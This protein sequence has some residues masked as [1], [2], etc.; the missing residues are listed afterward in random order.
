MGS[1]RERVYAA[2][3]RAIDRSVGRIMA[4]VRE[5]GLADNTII[6]FSS[7]N[8]GPGYIGLPQINAPYRG[9]KLTL[10]EGGIRVP[11]FVSW[12]SRIA[13]GTQVS[14]PVTH[15]DLMPTLAAAGRSALPKGVEIDGVDI[16]PWARRQ[17]AA[18]AR[19]QETIFW[20]SA[21]YRVVRNGDW[22]LQIIERPRGV[23]LYDLAKDPTERTNLASA[24]PDIVARLTSLLDAHQRGARPLLYPPMLEAP[25]AIDKTLAEKVGPDD[26][27]A[28]WPN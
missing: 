9:W 27:I 7:D 26:L 20:Q 16:M 25:I 17:V 21:G 3:I 4:A 5:Q 15:I 2:M 1:H 10:F 23:F 6:V 24:R 22:K 14:A 11:M 19:P 12:P 8:G 13:P 28:Y 18:G